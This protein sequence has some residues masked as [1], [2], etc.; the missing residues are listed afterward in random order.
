MSNKLWILFISR[1]III[2]SQIRKYGWEKLL[3]LIIVR[4]TIIWTPRVV[5]VECQL[6][7]I[8]Y[9]IA[10]ITF[11]TNISEMGSKKL[12]D[13]WETSYPRKYWPEMSYDL[14]F[15]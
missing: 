5:D 7:T 10:I 13:L 15:K 9:P 14:H 6:S 4:R 11:Q 8:I 1:L 2:R 3:K 12:N